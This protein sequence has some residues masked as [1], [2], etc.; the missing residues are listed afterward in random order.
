MGQSNIL[1]WNGS[2][3]PFTLVCQLF[4]FD[5]GIAEGWEINLKPKKN[6]LDRFSI[7]RFRL[8]GPNWTSTVHDP[9]FHYHGSLENHHNLKN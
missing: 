2:L 9:F 7:F 3:R 4:G 5:F 8:F 6:V 1:V